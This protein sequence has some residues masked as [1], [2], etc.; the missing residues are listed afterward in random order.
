MIG[1]M[2][3]YLNEKNGSLVFFANTPRWKFVIFS[4]KFIG[5]VSITFNPLI[6]VKIAKN[7]RKWRKFQKGEG[8]TKIPTVEIFQI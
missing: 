6:P 3:R 8:V 5:T 7:D 1:H 2:Y 4:E